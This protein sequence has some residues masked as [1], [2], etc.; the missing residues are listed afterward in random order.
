[1]LDFNLKFT[2]MLKG[3]QIHILK[4]FFPKLHL[5]VFS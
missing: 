5:A 4:L 2:C 1:M 3:D